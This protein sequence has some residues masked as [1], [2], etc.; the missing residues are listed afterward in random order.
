MQPPQPPE[1][2]LFCAGGL[3]ITPPLVSSESSTPRLKSLSFSTNDL[4]FSAFKGATPKE[5]SF[6]SWS[7]KMYTV[8]LNKPAKKKR[9]A[10]SK[11]YIM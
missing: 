4:R 9:I 6:E 5:E 10:A 7:K 2:S 8:E 11:C 1:D 3:P